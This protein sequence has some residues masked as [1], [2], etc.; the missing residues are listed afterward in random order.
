[1]LSLT[2]CWCIFTFP[3]AHQFTGIPISAEIHLTCLIHFHTSILHFQFNNL[4]IQKSLSEHHVPFDFR[5]EMPFIPI[6]TSCQ[7]INLIGQCSWLGDHRN[8]LCSRLLNLFNLTFLFL[9]HSYGLTCSR[10]PQATYTPS[11]PPLFTPSPH[12]G[13]SGRQ[14]PITK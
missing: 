12:P 7:S 1:M 8:N 10:I 14:I 11:L 5:L 9:P 4:L 13:G 2:H 6:L 3:I